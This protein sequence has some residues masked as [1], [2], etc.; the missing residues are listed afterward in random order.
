MPL[1]V[2]IVG[3]GPVGLT[4][5][6][7]LA[8]FGVPVRIIDK[9]PHRTDKSKA[10]VIWSRTLELLERSGVS[11]ALVEA[12]YKVEGVTIS[13]DKRPVGRLT[14][15][16]IPSAYQ[17]ALMLP[18]SDTERILE[19]SLS[20]LGIQVDREVEL[21]N[22]SEGQEKVDVRLHLADGS[23]ENVEA[24]WLIGCDGAHSTVR[25]LLGKEFHGE[26]SL[27]DWLLAD[28]HLV[29]VPRT[30][31]I[32]IGW[33]SE[34]VLATFPISDNRYRIVADVGSA[35][36]SSARL[37][38]PTLAD[39]QTVLDKRF[40]GGARATDAVWLSSFRINERKVADY[41]GG[42]AFLAGDAAHVHSPMGG[43]GMNTGIQDVCNLA[44]KLALVVHGKAAESL[45]D[46]Y[47]LERSPVAETVLGVT[48]RITSLATVKNRFVQ[49]V[50]NHTASLVLGIAPARKFA[51]GIA[52]E[53]AISYP[54]S[55][56][57]GSDKHFEPHPGQ[58]APIR[59]AE[60]PVGT[61]DTPRFAIFGENDGIPADLLS[62]YDGLLEP[63]VRKSFNS[64]GLWIVRPDGYAAVSTESGNW[65]AVSTYLDNVA[66]KGSAL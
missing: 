36:S 24:S 58:R 18:Q 25:H 51:S 35:H 44:W 29:N 1:P 38:E 47:S 27:I 20:N 56:L 59:E 7:E 19:E 65:N 55:P 39:V 8:R 46:S 40:P 17:F 60:M 10:I 26:T 49:A 48:G 2:L 11:Q 64:K 41:R 57:N 34:G 14:M 30:P 13:A 50:R 21:V 4:M 43:Q 28:I 31:E 9:A 45:L 37:P 63:S 61:G 23:E 66:A 33:H 52:S 62:R 5:A 53:I 42:R 12:G 3:A 15:N 32:N 6:V 16:G 22:F 54:H